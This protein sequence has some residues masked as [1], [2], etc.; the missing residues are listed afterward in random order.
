[1]TRQLG[2]M[3]R[4][5]GV[6]GFLHLKTLLGVDHHVA[7]QRMQR[8]REQAFR[9]VPCRHELRHGGGVG[10]LCLFA[11]VIGHEFDIRHAEGP[12]RVAIRVAQQHDW[13]RTVAEV[14]LGA[15]Q[16]CVDHGQR[17]DAGRAKGGLYGAQLHH[18]TAAERTVQPAKEADQEWLAAQIEKGDHALAIGRGQRERRNGLSGLQRQS[19]VFH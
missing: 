18:L 6:I 15:V 4:E 8:R 2:S 12:M 19:L 14:Q 3:G 9:V 10:P 13:R 17:L 7:F 5:N 16:G 11:S 1:M